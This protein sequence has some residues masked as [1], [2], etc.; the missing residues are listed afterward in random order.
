MNFKEVKITPKINK[1]YHPS[2]V[3]VT[4]GRA[5]LLLYRRGKRTGI[6]AVAEESTRTNVAIHLVIVEI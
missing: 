1:I 6:K 5:E 2:P 4:D 3:R